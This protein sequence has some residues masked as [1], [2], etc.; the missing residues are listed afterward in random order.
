MMIRNCLS[1]KTSPFDALV[2]TV[3]QKNAHCCFCGQEKLS[4]TP[5]F[6]SG[7]TLVN[8][9]RHA[10]EKKNF[11]VEWTDIEEVKYLPLGNGETKTAQTT[12]SSLGAKKVGKYFY[13]CP[14]SEGKIY[15]RGFKNK[16]CNATVEVEIKVSKY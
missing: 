16:G 3:C 7:T 2:F 11:A 13:I 9:V 10:V 1:R 4:K 12:Y 14:R 8:G 6:V 15:M 5:Y